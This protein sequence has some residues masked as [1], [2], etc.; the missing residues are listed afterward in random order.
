MKKKT[1]GNFKFNFE[2]YK[3]FCI[4]MQIKENNYNSIIEY[5]KFLKFIKEI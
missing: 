2:D 3:I 5:R 1:F 4:C